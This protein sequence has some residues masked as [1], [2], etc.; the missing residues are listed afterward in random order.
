MTKLATI[1]IG[2]VGNL[3]TA[4]PPMYNLYLTMKERLPDQITN[5]E[6]LV[7]SG[8]KVIN[9]EAIP[10][11]ISQVASVNGD[12]RC[13]FKKQVQFAAVSERLC[14]ISVICKH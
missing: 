13:T 10:E 8:K 7:A 6:T 9:P 3:K 4:S 2:L 1:P 12:I 11:L 14:F 5:E